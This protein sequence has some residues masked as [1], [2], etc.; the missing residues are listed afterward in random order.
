MILQ[1]LAKL[2]GDR[3]IGIHEPG[4]FLHSCLGQV[5]QALHLLFGII[6]ELQA[7]VFTPQLQSVERFIR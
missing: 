3:L 5:H 6:L 2:V 1:A 4:H 7:K